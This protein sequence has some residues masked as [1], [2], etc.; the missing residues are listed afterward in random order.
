MF[1]MKQN[2]NDDALSGKHFAHGPPV[3]ARNYPSKVDDK[4][5][6]ELEFYKEKLRFLCKKF[7]L[8]MLIYKPDKTSPVKL[9]I[10][11]L[12]DESPLTAR[13]VIRDN[14]FRQ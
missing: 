6:T 8:Q 1:K 2:I 5:N 12:K 10:S 9:Q 7:G 14:G 13:T 3:S 11:P 4:E